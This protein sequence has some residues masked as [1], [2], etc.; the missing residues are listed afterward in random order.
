MPRFAGPIPQ[1]TLGEVG[2]LE[3]YPGVWAHLESTPTKV[4]A[5]GVRTERNEHGQRR[6]LHGVALNVEIDLEGFRA[7]VPCGIADKPVASLN[8]LGLDVSALDVEEMLGE[9]LERRLGGSLECRASGPECGNH[10]FGT[11]AHSPTAQSRG[12]S[13]RGPR[14]QRAKAFVAAH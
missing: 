4:A 11:S 10:V 12:R 9:E 13:R 2:R 6:T 5:V 1:S 8:S 3:G 14:D 7:I